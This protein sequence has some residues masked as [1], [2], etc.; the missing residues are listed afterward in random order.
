MKA[1]K[2]KKNN[3]KSNVLIVQKLI[4]FVSQQGVSIKF[5]GHS[6]WLA[7]MWRIRRIMDEVQRGVAPAGLE[8]ILRNPGWRRLLRVMLVRR[9]IF[10]RVR[11]LDALRSNG[12]QPP[13]KR[14]PPSP[15]RG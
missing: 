13:S 8:L 10:C 11:F 14:S 12:S 6:K 2:M 3:L 5:Q 1:K 4:D 15:K 7:R 9:Y